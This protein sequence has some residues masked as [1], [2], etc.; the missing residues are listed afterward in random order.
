[1]TRNV[2]IVSE[3]T[4]LS[5]VLRTAGETAQSTLPVVN[6]DGELAGTIVMR[7]LLT[8]IGGGQELGPLV[9]AFDICN[10]HGPTV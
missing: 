7:D 1:M 6:S 8:M 2:T 9:N 5:E 3:N 10:A 4:S